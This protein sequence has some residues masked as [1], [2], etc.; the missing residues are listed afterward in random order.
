VLVSAVT[1]SPSAP[2]ETTS[3]R[4]LVV[5]ER[6]DG[7]VGKHLLDETAEFKLPTVGRHASQDDDALETTQRFDPGFRQQPPAP[8]AS[9][10]PRGR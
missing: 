9:Q 10:E 1:A 3:L 6:K 4:T 5:T 8:W 7:I 2:G